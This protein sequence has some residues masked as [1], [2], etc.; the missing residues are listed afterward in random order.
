ITIGTIERYHA[1][2]NGA[3]PMC[4]P[5]LSASEFLNY[6]ILDVLVTFDY[7]F[8]NVLGSPFEV[9]PSVAEKARAAFQAEPEKAA[10]YANQIRRPRVQNLPGTI[11]MYQRI[12]AELTHRAGGNPFDNNNRVYKGFGDDVALNRGVKRYTADRTGREYVQRYYSPTGRI[13]DPVLA[14]VVTG[15]HWVLSDWTT[16]YEVLAGHSGTQDRFVARF[17]DGQGHCGY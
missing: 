5:L 4:G 11:A 3:L 16:G 12:A 1:E 14:L 17:V 13:A 15:D 2:Y 8:P 9:N 6:G 7:F 10:A